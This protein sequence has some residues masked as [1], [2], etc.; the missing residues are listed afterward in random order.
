M[1]QQTQGSATS[2]TMS[3]TVQADADRAFEVFT[4]GM[5]TWWNADHHIIEAPFADMVFEPWVGGNI[6]DIGDDGS[7]CRWSRVL[8]YE[9]PSR[10]VFSWDIKPNWELET[11]PARASE[12]EV[13]FDPQ[14]PDSTLVTLEHR[15]L[16]RH[17]DGWEELSAVFGS[18]DGWGS[19]LALFAAAV[20]A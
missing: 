11:D 12:I 2:V 14:G 8:A 17:G 18:P 3:V 1:T 19:T 9:P 13:R 15:H 20:S 10:V 6:Y 4:T 7:E 5:R 16:D